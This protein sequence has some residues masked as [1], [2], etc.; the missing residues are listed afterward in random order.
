MF[1]SNHTLYSFEQWTGLLNFGPFWPKVTVNKHQISPLSE[2][3]RSV[4]A[5]NFKE[6]ISSN[7]TGSCL[8]D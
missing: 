4:P 3:Q 6:H 8:P 5:R 2:N 7:L 1:K